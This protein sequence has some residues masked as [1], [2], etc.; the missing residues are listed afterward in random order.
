MSGKLIGMENNF[1]KKKELVIEKIQNYF[2]HWENL[3]FLAILLEIYQFFLL[4]GQL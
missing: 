1:S 3:V 4:V 2:K